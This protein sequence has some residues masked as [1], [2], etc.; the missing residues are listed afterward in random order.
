MIVV[1]EEFVGKVLRLRIYRL[2]LENLF[3]VLVTR[4]LVVVLL[5]LL[6][7]FVVNTW[8]FNWSLPLLGLN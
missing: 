4:H 3:L 6:V 2:I 1:A 5:R 8:V 7:G